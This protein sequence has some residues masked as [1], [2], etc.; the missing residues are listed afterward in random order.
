[1]TKYIE[2]VKLAAC[3]SCIVLIKVD[4]LT[5]KSII[6]MSI[7]TELNIITALPT[8]TL[9]KKDEE[10]SFFIYGQPNNYGKILQY[11]GSFILKSNM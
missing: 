6:R 3:L 8:V 9:L 5:Q 7:D 1:M 10:K 4:S 2:I 11:T